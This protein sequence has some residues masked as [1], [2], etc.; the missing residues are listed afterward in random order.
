VLANANTAPPRTLPNCKRTAESRGLDVVLRNVA[1]RDDVIAAIREVKAAGAEAINF[2]ATPMFSINAAPL[3]AEV[4]RLRL[5]SIFQWP[6]DADAGALLSYGPPIT[7]MYRVRGRMMVQVLRGAAPADISIEQPT[8][9]ELV[10]NLKTAKALG[11][12]LPQTL[13]VSADEVIGV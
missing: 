7:E 4:T 8:K 6:D 3:I 1:K 9:F 2:L 11:R 5:A 13:I 10:V 12:T